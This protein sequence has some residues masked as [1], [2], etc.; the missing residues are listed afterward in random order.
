MSTLFLVS[1]PIGNLEDMSFRAVRIL[2]EVKLIACEDTRH[3]AKLLNHY[4]ISTPSTSFFDHNKSQK[5][6][7]IIEA[8]S[9]GDIAL[10]SDAG[11]PALNDPGFL[12]VNAAIEAGLQLDLCFLNW[13]KEMFMS[14]H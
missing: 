3:T 14:T 12:L 7:K 6:P 11:T 5:I 10:V 4:E 2:K 8:L 1:T 9:N 13:I